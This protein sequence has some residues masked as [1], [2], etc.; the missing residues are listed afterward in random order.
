M[1]R[2]LWRLTA[3]SSGV[4]VA[5]SMNIGPASA[6]SSDDHRPERNPVQIADQVARTEQDAD[7]YA[8]SEQFLPINANVPVQILSLGSNGGDTKQSNSSTAESAAVNKAGTDQS[9][10]QYQSIPK[11][12]DH[13]GHGP[14][15]HDGWKP[16]DHKG[17]DRKGHD[18]WKPDDHKGHG[19]KGHDGW[20]PDDHKGHGP[21]GHDGWKPEPPAV[22]KAS[23]KAWTDQDA[24]SEAKSKQFLPV[25]ANVPVQFLSLGHNGGDT[26]QSNNSTAR[27]FAGNFAWTDQS[28]DQTQ[29]WKG[30]DGWKPDGHKG[31]D[32]KGY[33]P[34]GH[35]GWKDDKGHGPKGHDDRKGYDRPTFQG[36]SQKAS[37]DQNAESS[38]KSTQI[39]PVNVNAPVQILSLGHNGG[40]TK[41]SNNSTAESAA[42]NQAETDQSAKQ[43]QQAGKAPA[44]QG[45]SQ[46]ASTDQNAESSAK[47]TQILPVNVN[48]PVQILSLGHNGGD[49]KQSNNSTA[50]SAAINQ[51]ETDQSA[52]QYQQAG[53]APAFQ[54]ASQEASTDQNAESS[55]KSTQILPV[56]A[57]VPVQILSLGSNGGDTSQSNN[58][59]A[60]SAAVN[61]AGTSQG[62]GQAQ[63][64][65]GG[66]L[67]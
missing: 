24:K 20:K 6:S 32:H 57:N 30:L 66:L 26:K 17:H 25:N 31:D 18:G 16:D 41:Q 65:L 40:D 22:Q 50:E 46:E 15:G 14:K 60:E 67:G 43:Y 38:A 10:R 54:G 13:K 29:A 28:I 23:Q 12:D 49:T 58:S 44:F 5:L 9:V 61:Q 52:K 7:S 55:A 27:S 53:K 39:L 56:N 3:A 45:A 4:L 62:I 21:K 47:S 2:T 48:A 37:T 51:A 34:K 33:D 8:K 42:I 1:K 59:T 63:G 64:I 11:P 36:A 35:D 19:P